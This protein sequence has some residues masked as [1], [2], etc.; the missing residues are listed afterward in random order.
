MASNSRFSASCKKHMYMLYFAD[1]I[2]QQVQ[3]IKS[4]VRT[5]LPEKQVYNIGKM[6]E[7]CKDNTL[8][9]F[10]MQAVPQKIS[11]YDEE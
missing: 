1:D 2:V 3:K 9:L 5:S 8:I 11:V 10:G 4:E 6:R 7:I